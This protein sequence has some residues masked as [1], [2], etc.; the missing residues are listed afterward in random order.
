[1]LGLQCSLCKGILR[2]DLTYRDIAIRTARLLGWRQV[3]KELFCPPCVN[4][5]R[6][7]RGNSD[8]KDRKLTG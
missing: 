8:L 2:I 5:L 7:D 1:M 6:Q 4:R 3:D